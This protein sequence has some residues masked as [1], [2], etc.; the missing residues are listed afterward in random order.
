MRIV[1]LHLATVWRTLATKEQKLIEARLPGQQ[2]DSPR[3]RE[4]LRQLRRKLKRRAGA[5]GP[6]Q[7]K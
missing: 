4:L 6:R 5:A 3:V 2:P 7:R 1:D